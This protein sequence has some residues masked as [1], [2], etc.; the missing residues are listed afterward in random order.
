ME[1][2][3]SFVVAAF[4]VWSIFVQIWQAVQLRRCIELLAARSYGEFASGQARMKQT[5]PP[6]TVN[7]G[8]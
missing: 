5:K 2:L 7:L 1:S 4:A 8:F 6:E 3:L